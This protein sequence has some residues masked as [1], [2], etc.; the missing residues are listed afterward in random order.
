MGGGLREAAL[1]GP[2]CPGCPLA[3]SHGASIGPNQDWIF[4]DLCWDPKGGYESKRG[5][6]L[7]NVD[8]DT[9]VGR[10][11][12][13][14]LLDRTATSNPTCQLRHIHRHLGDRVG[15]WANDS[16]HIIAPDG[17]GIA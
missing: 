6:V 9:H 16:E 8:D 15:Y 7:Y 11:Y 10:A 4:L 17:A 3:H 12:N 5:W 14:F 2:G 1:W 13:P